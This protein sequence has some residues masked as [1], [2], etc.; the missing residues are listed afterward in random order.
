MVVA[1]V[2]VS[3][4]GVATTGVTCMPGHHYAFATYQLVLAVI[5]A[6]ALRRQRLRRHHHPAA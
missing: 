4:A 6:V 5:L 1:L 2:V 3:F